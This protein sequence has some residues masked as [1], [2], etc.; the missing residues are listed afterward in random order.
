MILDSDDPRGTHAPGRRAALP[1]RN[2]IA[3][4]EIEIATR[5]R[6]WLRLWTLPLCS[7]LG[8][9]RIALAR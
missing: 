4:R 2:S 9:I 8:C 7:Q 5:L 3:L 6:L 1:W